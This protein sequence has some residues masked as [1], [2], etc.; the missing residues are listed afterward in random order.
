MYLHL[1]GRVLG[2]PQAPDEVLTSA[3]TASVEDS[4][5]SV[6]PSKKGPQQGETFYSRLSQTLGAICLHLLA[7][8]WLEDL[9]QGPSSYFIRM[10]F[11]CMV[12]LDLVSSHLNDE[13]TN[14]GI[15]WLSS[16][17][18]GGFCEPLL[19]QGH[20]SE[21]LNT[22]QSLVHAHFHAY[23]LLWTVSVAE[24]CQQDSPS[25]THQCCNF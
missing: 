17:E 3:A 20:V 8:V 12:L 9:C 6:S 23:L 24:A 13:W 1:D 10:V 22:E 14:R 5:L 18:S 11:R 25:G 7:G 21:E 16:P 4:S 15:L 19:G 2:S